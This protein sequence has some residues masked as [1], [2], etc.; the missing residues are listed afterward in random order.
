M[1]AI[2]KMLPAFTVCLLLGSIVSGCGNK[3]KKAEL[4]NLPQEVKPVAVAIV[5]DSPAA[6]ASV[7]NY[8]LQRPYPLKDIKDSAAMVAYY[9]TLIDDTLKKTIEEAPDSTW[10]EQG[11]RGWTLYDG[12]YIWIDNGKIYAVNYISS[13]EANMLDS[14]RKEEISSL[15]PALRDGWTPVV[16]MIDTIDGAIFRIDT[17]ND[18]ADY[19]TTGE[20]RLAGYSM[21]IDLS[22]TPTIVLYGAL[23]LEGSMGNRFYHFSDSVGTRADYSPDIIDDNDSVPAIE[24]ERN[25]KIKKFK[26]NPGYWLDHVKKNEKKRVSNGSAIVE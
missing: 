26:A 25:G 9:P 5:S 8:P 2:H 10:Q 24:L 12:S 15:D 19:G 11:W 7:V 1:K 17:K 16:C 13:R 18:T 20:Y 6:F 14:L 21:N 4:S 3:K 23:D 22:G